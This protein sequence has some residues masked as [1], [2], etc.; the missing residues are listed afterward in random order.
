MSIKCDVILEWTAMP[1]QL[2][3]LGAAR[4]QGVEDIVVDGT[5]WKRID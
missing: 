4:P 1:D 3:A 2:T 5:S